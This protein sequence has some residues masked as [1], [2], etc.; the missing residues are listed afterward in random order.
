[1]RNPFQTK[2]SHPRGSNQEASHSHRSTTRVH[3]SPQRHPRIDRH[4]HF[5][6]HLIITIRAQ[7]L[8]K[9]GGCSSRLSVSSPSH[10]RPVWSASSSSRSHSSRSQSSSAA[11]RTSSSRTNTDQQQQDQYSA[12]VAPQQPEPE[13]PPNQPNKDNQDKDKTPPIHLA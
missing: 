5:H 12:A 1:M 4:S 2:S 3:P 6:L 7:T 13:R 9:L 10:L 8:T 11:S